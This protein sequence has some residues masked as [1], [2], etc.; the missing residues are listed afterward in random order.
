VSNP[1]GGK[2]QKMWK[3]KPKAKAGNSAGKGEWR[4]FKKAKAP[5][6][7]PKKAKKRGDR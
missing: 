1:F 2:A 3:S 6:P 5:P 7:P 4:A